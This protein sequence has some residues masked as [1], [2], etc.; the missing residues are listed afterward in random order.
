MGYPCIRRTSHSL[1][2]LASL[3]LSD[4]SLRADDLAVALYVLMWDT[5]KA[6]KWL[7]AMTADTLTVTPEAFRERFGPL[8]LALS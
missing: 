6:V 7:R 1:Q 8:G 2:R 4:S 3:W 5:G